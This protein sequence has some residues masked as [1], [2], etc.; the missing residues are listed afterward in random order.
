VDSVLVKEIIFIKKMISRLGLD[1]FRQAIK[2]CGRAKLV[3]VG[4][5]ELANAIYNK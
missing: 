3:K 4:L 1:H 2:G 5:L